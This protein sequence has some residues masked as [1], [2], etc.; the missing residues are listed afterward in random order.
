MNAMKYDERVVHT[1]ASIATQLLGINLHMISMLLSTLQLFFSQIEIGLYQP[2][3]SLSFKK[4]VMLLREVWIK[5]CGAP[6]II[7]SY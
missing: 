7:I 6:I 2:L 5:N 3:F 4:Y 1:V